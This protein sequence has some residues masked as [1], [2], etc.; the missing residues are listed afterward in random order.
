MATQQQLFRQQQQIEELCAAALRALTGDPELHYRGRRL[1]HGPRPLAVNAPHL[2]LAQ[3]STDLIAYR[4]VIDGVALRLQHSDAELHRRLSP[5]EPVERLLFEQIE[6]LRVEGLVAQ[7]MPG[8]AHNL[9][10]R[11]EAWLREFY[12]SGLTETSLGVL[13]FTISQICWSR[14]TGLPV[15]EETEGVI[16]ATRASIAPMIGE[17]VAGLIRNRNDQAAFAPHALA[18]ARI[19][20]DMLRNAIAEQ[21]QADEEDEADQSSR[22]FSLLLDFDTQDEESFAT[23]TTG[24]SKSF[25]E[26]GQ[27]YRIFTTDY[28]SEVNAG[29]QVRT[30]LLKEYREQLDVR[31]AALGI[32]IR[33]LARLFA[34]HLSTPQRDGWQFGEE[35]GHLDGRR[36]AQLVTSPAERRLFRREQYKPRA[37][38]LVSFLIDCSGSMKMHSESLTL[39]IDICT[40]ALE[41]AGVTTEILGFT[42]SAWSG[43]RAQQEWMRQGR[44]RHPGRL[45]EVRHLVFKD[46]ERPWRRARR[47]IAALLKHDLY[48]EGI[49][50][51]AVDWAC[52]RMLGR[53]EERRILIVL[54]DGCPMDT[55]TNLANDSFYL[56]NHLK[57]VVARHERQGDVEILGIGVGLDLGPFYRHH[58]T[59]D[60]A[61]T[62]DNALFDEIARLIVAHRRR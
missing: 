54:S 23:A 41:M 5:T 59:I 39:M 45:N 20:G 16:E 27:H 26:A 42:T 36:L 56:D 40:R 19:I 29:S 1:H 34:A 37:N 46:A 60:L 49:D 22:A 25:T 14:L 33:R 61:Q 2:R 17:S 32:N 57:A 24:H 30:A 35:E 28:D 48:R 47:D 18:L 51:E 52:S 38:C 62:L 53:D 58:L 3:D 8:M 9:Q 12:G 4:G 31:I 10:Q 15:P 44:P 21:P 55:A 11:F 6:Q 13:L 50:G 43:G 7:T